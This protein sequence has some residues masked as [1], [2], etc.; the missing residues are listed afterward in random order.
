MKCK[1]LACCLEGDPLTDI[2]VAID[3]VKC[4]MKGGT[5]VIGPQ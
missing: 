3:K 5:V 1:A 4:V 2:H